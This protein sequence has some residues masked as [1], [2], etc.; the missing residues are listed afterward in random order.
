[1]ESGNILSSLRVSS[2][3]GI[4]AISGVFRILEK[5]LP[6]D[7]LLFANHVWTICLRLFNL[8]VRVMK[9]GQVYSVYNK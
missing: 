3:W 8:R 1:M 2:E 6:S 7:N 5:K 4:G 9:V